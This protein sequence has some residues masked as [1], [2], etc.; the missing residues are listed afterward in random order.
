MNAIRY[1]LLQDW[2]G[3]VRESSWRRLRAFCL[4]LGPGIALWAAG[5]Y[6]AI[7]VGAVGR[8]CGADPGIREGALEAALMIS[9]ALTFLVSFSETLRE[10]WF[11]QERNMLASSP[12]TTG[13]VISYRWFFAMVRTAPWGAVFLSLPLLLAL[14]V[15]PQSLPGR[16]ESILL[17]ALYGVWISLG[18]LMAASLTAAAW[19]RTGCGRHGVFVTFYVIQIA[20]LAFLLFR[21]L[22]P[23]GWE[24][25]S[26]Q[27]RSPG[28]FSLMPHRQL[29][30]FLVVEPAKGIAGFL[31]TGMVLGGTM[32]L[33]GYA[34][35]S[36]AARAAAARLEESS[37]AVSSRGRLA[38]P[39]SGFSRKRSWAIFQKD[40]IDM[41]RNPVYRGSYLATLLLWPVGLWAQAKGRPSSGPS[42]MVLALIYMVPFLLS[43]RAVSREYPLLE[44][45]RLVLPRSYSLLDAKLRAHVPVNILLTLGAA[46]PFM[47]LLKPGMRLQPCLWFLAATVW[48]VPVFTAFSL[49]LG[50]FFP[51]LSPAPSAIGVRLAG[52]ILYLPPAACLYSLLLNRMIWA[53]AGYSLFLLLLSA[54]A[55]CSAQRRLACLTERRTA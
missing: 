24:E 42:A 5:G 18:A 48:F 40:L 4:F 13:A 11:A 37:G 35:C 36:I 50:T 27:T 43:A 25:F 20:L 21:F 12:M 30:A 14:S 49:A 39:Q 31:A 32:I 3:N 38:R 51:D 55:Y 15:S 17:I 41:I 6:H 10:I 16:T 23:A 1:R 22:T 47:V 33:S 26:L 53:T 8:A 34:F 52:L 54:G 19:N 7:L 44:L 29:A 2:R 45:Y 28:V 46:I 9:G